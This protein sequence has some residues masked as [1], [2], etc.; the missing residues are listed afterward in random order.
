MSSIVCSK[1]RVVFA[2]ALCLIA[3]A[4]V[5]VLAEDRE[6]WQEPDRVMAD[7]QLTPGQAVADVG[8]GYGYFTF[9]MASA[10][11]DGG[12][13]YAVDIS[14]DA[15]KAVA[16]QARNSGITNIQPVRSEPTDTKLGDASVNA[17]LFCD[18]LHHVPETDRLPLVTDVVR[19]LRPGGYLYIID[20][21]KSRDIPFD[22]YEILIPH[23]DLVTLGESAGCTFDAEFHYLKYQ[24]F[25]RFRKP[26]AE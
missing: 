13:V 21:R 14:D 17:A 4:S 3:V 5:R 24:V 12:Q 9:R 6:D 8:C 10:V 11:G 2:V 26:P 15:L 20:W 16:E 18:V 22:P 23:E 19:A 7:L 25:L 1:L